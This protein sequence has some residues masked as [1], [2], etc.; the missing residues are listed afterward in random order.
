M[1]FAC[2]TPLICIIFRVFISAYAVFEGKASH[3]KTKSIKNVYGLP[4][5][6][7]EKCAGGNKQ[8]K[9]DKNLEININ[10]SKLIKEVPFAKVFILLI[11]SKFN[12]RKKLLCEL[13]PLKKNEHL[14]IVSNL[15]YHVQLTS[16]R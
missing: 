13:K 10:Y 5:F 14:N 7:L 8:Q 4:I 1:L 11:I 3:S 15:R 9:Y 16:E 2:T 12:D 6:C